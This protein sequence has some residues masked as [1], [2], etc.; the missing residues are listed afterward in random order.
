MCIYY[1]CVCM[2]ICIYVYAKVKIMANVNEETCD[3]LFQINYFT[4]CTP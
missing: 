1:I 3:I 2:C 4:H